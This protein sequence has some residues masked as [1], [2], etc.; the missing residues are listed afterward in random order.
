MLQKWQ[1]IVRIM[2]PS[3]VPQIITGV[4]LA[5]GRIFGEA[6]ALIFTAGLTTPFLNS[7]ADFSSPMH[8]LNPFRPAE[9][10]AVHIWKLNSEGIVPDAGLI[11]T[12]SAA[13]LIVMVLMFN[14]LAR[15]LASV[16]H[17]RFFSGTRVRKTK[18][19]KQLDVKAV[20]CHKVMA[21]FSF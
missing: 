14:V 7:A 21:F 9:T 5:A 15:L 6:A 16:L 2:I 19:K 20:T 8:P 10:L 11:A 1:T 18:N 12:K 3:A 13:I 17:S 4:I